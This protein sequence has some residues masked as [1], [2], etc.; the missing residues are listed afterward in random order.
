MDSIF[1]TNNFRRPFSYDNGYNPSTNY[2]RPVIS[3]RASYKSPW[4]SP[5]TLPTTS[6][7]VK[8]YVEDV[9]YTPA[10][11]IISFPDDLFGRKKRFNFENPSRLAADLKIE[12]ISFLIKLYNEDNEAIKRKENPP[13]GLRYLP[14][15]VNTISFS[16]KLG[17]EIIY[18][19]SFNNTIRRKIYDNDVGRRSPGRVR[20]PISLN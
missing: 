6:P 14:T 20:F 16:K 19:V 9:T 2:Y 15:K 8:P 13:H 10:F 1:F 3:D 12:I 18:D 17:N 11:V 5:N 4:S 7:I